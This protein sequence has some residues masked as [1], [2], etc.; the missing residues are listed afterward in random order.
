MHFGFFNAFAGKEKF[1]PDTACDTEKRNLAV[2]C[3]IPLAD[4]LKPIIKP[5]VF[6]LAL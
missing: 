6:T 4:F 3:N 2:A 1:L 5:T